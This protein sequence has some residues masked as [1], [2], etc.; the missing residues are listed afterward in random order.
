[1]LAKSVA[2]RFTTTTKI[3]AYYQYRNGPNHND[4]TSLQSASFSPT[5]TW[6]FTKPVALLVGQRCMSSNEAFIL[7]MSA[8]DHVTTIGDTTRGSSGNPQEYSLEDGTK[9]MISSWVAHRADKTP[10][11]DIGLFPDLPIPASE[12]IFNNH[13][14]VLKKAIEILK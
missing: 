3:Y 9:Y 5:G 13:D 8:L 14:R 4:F 10:F 1:L 2:G 6:Q 11:E 12:S 7:M